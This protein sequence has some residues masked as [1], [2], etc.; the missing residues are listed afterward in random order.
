VSAAATCENG[1]AGCSQGGGRWLSAL[2]R[3]TGSKP[4]VA[5]WRLCFPVS[6]PCVRLHYVRL[7]PMKECVRI[8]GCL[9]VPDSRRCNAVRTEF[10]GVVAS[11]AADV[12]SFP[13]CREWRRGHS[14]ASAQPFRTGVSVAIGN[15]ACGSVR[16]A[17]GCTQPGRLATLAQRGKKRDFRPRN[18][19]AAHT[20]L[21]RVYAHRF[22]LLCGRQTTACSQK[23]GCFRKHWIFSHRNALVFK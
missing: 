15:E 6:S 3:Q 20:C 10:H 14:P 19:H 23:E 22:L 21:A 11:V 18:L 12:H 1:V 7:K 2:A 5:I 16:Y 4:N 13:L 9:T 8:A 17:R